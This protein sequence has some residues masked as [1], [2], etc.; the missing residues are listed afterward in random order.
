MQE[1]VSLRIKVLMVG[2]S[3]S[4]KTNI[5]LRHFKNT[6]N[7]EQKPTQ[8]S[9]YV[10]RKMKYKKSFLEIEVI[11]VGGS[12]FNSVAPQAFHGVSGI[13][14]VYD[15]SSKESFEQ[16]KK[17]HDK[18]NQYLEVRD[19]MGILVAA[20]SD[21]LEAVEESQAQELASDLK[22]VRFLTSKF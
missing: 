10:S 2:S 13:I 22:L 1:E 7:E 21:L 15:N 3:G 5:L 19:I 9:F 14:F 8:G 6:F 16:V 20:K 17:W 4:G 11:E 12:A 18:A